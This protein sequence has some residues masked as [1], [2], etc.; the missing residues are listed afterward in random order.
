MLKKGTN[1]GTSGSRYSES[2]AEML[3]LVRNDRRLNI[4]EVACFM[5]V[6]LNILE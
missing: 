5:L 6:Y 3:D 1:L 2:V 4:F